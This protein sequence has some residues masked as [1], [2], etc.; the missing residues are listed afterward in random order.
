M[1]NFDTYLFLCSFETKIHT[2]LYLLLM[3]DTIFYSKKTLK[4]KGKIIDLTNPIVMGILNIT[5]DSFYD[6][7]KYH[8]SYQILKQTE[9]MLQ[10]GATIIDVG[11]YSSRPQAE[12]IPEKE[13]K[14]RIVF[15]IHT[16]LKHFP[17]TLI[18]IDTFRADIAETAICEGACMIND[19]SGGSL[20]AKMFETV[21]RLQVPYVLMH[22]KGTPQTMQDV[23]R[24]EQLIPEILT[25]FHQK[26]AIL[27]SLGVEDIM[28]DMGFGFAKTREQ[29]FL[30][31]QKLATFRLLNLPILVG[32]SRKSM[33]WKTLDTN[34]EDSLNGTTVLNTVAL[35]KGASI[36][37]VHDVKEAM[38]SIKLMES[39]GN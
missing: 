16:I 27:R 7:G 5:P 21:A 19:I 38:Q 9:K 39:L 18:S 11:G 24:Y 37:R 4:L 26:I 1:Y 3:R 34:A 22:M 17:N 33:I 28:I 29:S 23:A 36:L 8:S 10:E 31:L 20:D 13:E 15:A 14:K 30:L 6:G 2:I 32:I 12:D 25:Y 35:Q